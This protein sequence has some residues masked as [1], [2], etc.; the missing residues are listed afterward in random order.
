MRKWH[1]AKLI[2]MVTLTNVRI[3]FDGLNEELNVSFKLESLNPSFFKKIMS[4]ILDPIPGGGKKFLMLGYLNATSSIQI[5]RVTN[6]SNW[7]FERVVF[8]GQ[9]LIFEAPIDA[10]LEIHTGLMSSSILSDTIPC[11]QLVIEAEPEST[12]ILNE[13]QQAIEY[14]NEGVMAMK[15]QLPRDSAPSNTR[16]KARTA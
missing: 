6:I 5:A 4:Q 16:L 15:P 8:P 9:R 7:Y 12:S 3:E 11:S 2:R 13:K 14:Q 1:L 10:R